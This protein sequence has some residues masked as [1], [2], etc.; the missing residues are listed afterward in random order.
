MLARLKEP[1]TYAA[2]AAALAV[3]QPQAAQLVP[4]VGEVAVA[5]A[6]FVAAAVGVFGKEA[7]AKD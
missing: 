6:A 4:Y 2:I 3:F 5:V 1:S 7:G